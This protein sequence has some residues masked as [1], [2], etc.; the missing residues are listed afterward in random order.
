MSQYGITS[1]A[2]HDQDGTAD[3]S[4]LDD[5]KTYGHGFLLGMLVQR[6][7]VTSLGS[8]LIIPEI[9]CVIILRELCLRRGNPVP[10]SL[11]ARYQEIIDPKTGTLA[12]INS[13][14]LALVDSEGEKIKG[15]NGNL[16]SVSNMQIDRR[17]PHSS[18]RIVKQTSFPVPVSPAIP[19][20]HN[21]DDW[22]GG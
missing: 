15:I 11:E 2:D 16:P 9:E 19:V 18:A 21:L 20:K 5:C 13:G 12:Q 1:F 17:F 7:S 4:V 8:S 3:V 6:Y 14:K 10:A 22:A